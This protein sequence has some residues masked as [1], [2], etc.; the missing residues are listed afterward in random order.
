MEPASSIIKAF[1]GHAKV[2]EITNRH[3]VRTYAWTK[4]K[5]EGG[6]DGRIPPEPAED[7]LA[8]A[9]KNDLPITAE[10]FFP[11]PGKAQADDK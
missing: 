11:K 6:T 9:R 2:A 8:Y 10:D 7:L 3:R 4:K 1:G 5:S